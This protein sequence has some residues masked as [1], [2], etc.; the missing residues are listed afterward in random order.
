MDN[1]I[2]FLMRNIYF[3]IIIVFFLFSTM[4]KS[5][6]QEKKQQRMPTFG[7]EDARRPEQPV[8][9]S[10]QQARPESP[11][12][13]PQRP[14]TAKRS[15]HGQQEV[16]KSD[17][18]TAVNR[19]EEERNRRRAGDMGGRA[20][21]SLASANDRIGSMEGDLTNAPLNTASHHEKALSRAELRRAIVWSE[22]LARPRSVRSRRRY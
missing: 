2:E 17:D 22:I 14:E 4:S 19:A 13:Q 1:I 11:Q 8:R 3:V 5:K 9:P 21:S 10:P 15:Y 20:S 16:Y 12:S 6:K 7:G 18:R